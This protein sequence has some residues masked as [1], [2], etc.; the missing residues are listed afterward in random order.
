MLR[1]DLLKKGMLKKVHILFITFSMFYSLNGFSQSTNIPIDE[2]IYHLLDRYEI[3]RS[4]I[5]DNFYTSFKPYQRKGVARFVDVEF[6][7]FGKIVNADKF[8]LQYLANDNWEWSTGAIVENRPIFGLLYKSKTNLFSVSEPEFDLHVNPVLQLAGGF[9]TGKAVPYL[10]TRG[11]EVRGMINRKVG[12]YSFITE[13]QARFPSYVRDWISDFGAVPGEASWK[14]YRGEG[15]DFF[16]AKGHVSI[17]PVKNINIQL[18]QEKFFI[19]NGKRSLILSDFGSSYPFLKVQTEIWRFSYTNLFA[20]L[21]GDNPAGRNGI[22][23]NNHNYKKFFALHH[24]SL[25]LTD[26][27]NIGFFESIV[28]GDSVRS[29]LELEY[30]NPVIFYRAAEH[31][32]GSIISNVVLGMDAKW[33]F[34][35]RFQLYGQFV[36]DEFHLGYLREANGWWANKWA[37]QFGAKYIEV[38]GVQNLDFQFEWNRVRPYMYSHKSGYTNYTHYGQPVAHPFGANFD[39]KL[40]VFKYQPI[41]RL[42]FQV[43]YQW[44]ER[45]G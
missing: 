2:N 33:N 7:N 18:G 8:N 39:E 44:A 19:G 20:E 32:S 30:F 3:K 14:V 12:F 40:F 28:S 17:N 34:L 13:N 45:G 42:Q 25:N 41:K 21:R 35:E 1:G 43:Q 26:N 22:M 24:L 10:N 38:L 5:T 23:T 36:L 29:G 37:S 16:S 11:I 6:G 27:L 9:E 4:K 15:V 31:Y